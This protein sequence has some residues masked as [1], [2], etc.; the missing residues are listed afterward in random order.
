MFRWQR[1]HFVLA[2]Y[3]LLVSISAFVTVYALFLI[4]SDPGNVI[5][6]GLSLQRLV[7]LGSVSLA[8]ILTVV[9]AVKA[10]LNEPWSERVWLFLF[11]REAF[12]KRIRWGTVAVLLSGLIVS[13]MPLYRFWDFKDY[14]IRI[15]P[16]V[17][18]LTFISLLTF[19]VAWI[20]KYGL[21]W[22]HFLSALNAQ[23]KIL[24]IAL[25]SMTTFVLIWIFIAKTGMGLWVRDG[26]W[27]EAGV[28]ILGL[29]I[30]FAF[31]IGMGVLFLERSSLNAYLPTWS[32]FFI[33]F[34]IWGI[35]AFFWSRE[36]LRQSFFAPGPYQP[37]SAYHP[38][39]DAATF[40]IGSQF[41]LIG[42]GINNGVFFDRALYMAFLVFLHVF[43]EQDY[44][45]V[46]ALQ[47]AI[48]AVFP[49][50]LYLLGKD[51]YS[52]SFGSILAVLVILRG[53]NGI[54]AGSMINLAN[55]KQ[56]LTDFPTL[57][58]VA[59]FALMM[60]RWLK[61]PAKNYLYALWAGGIIGLAI[62]VRTNTL[63]LL[64]FA[65]LLVG[66][67]YWRQ[68][69]RGALVGFLL[70]LTMFASTF[71]W[72]FYNDISVFDLY[73][74]RIRIVIESR[75]PRPVTP[76]PAPQGSA[77]PSFDLANRDQGMIAPASFHLAS[78]KNNKYSIAAPIKLASLSQPLVNIGRGDA[79]ITPVPVFVT[80]HFLHNIIAS[81]FILPTTFD[82]H[83]LR[84][85]LKDG[86]PFWQPGWDG[87]NLAFDTGFF[88]ALNLLL[89]ALGI[90]AGWKFAGLSGWYPW[91]GS[92]SIILPM[93]LPALQADAMS[94]PWIGL[95]FSILRLAYSR[96]FFG[97]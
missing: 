19:V 87:K 37:D 42:Q 64:V 96:S 74:Y 39:S 15:F 93:L 4:P 22:L 5:F 77:S 23:K 66:I 60:V 97:E 67:V 68:K 50:V 6:L 9:F 31:A 27:Y 36:P 94:F 38:Y 80:I 8:G 14:F 34:L 86:A 53:I 90:G 35:T 45:Q 95:C 83:D 92:S 10:Y 82:L 75:Y 33:F 49:A 3:G 21:H 63:F 58:F 61:S 76:E 18:W 7:M 78:S 17:V 84:H 16:L 72:G 11:G 55:Q 20:E 81:V 62:M 1:F 57:I 56:L 43:A 44:V 47:A 69:M 48:Y 79:K 40:D 28:P 41:A 46:V 24:T 73:I 89:I 65:V 51:V 32:D 30:V 25:I 54:A 70:A 2:I 26:F 12:A 59:W 85:T 29:Q 88:L 52:R 13:F 91:G 71:A